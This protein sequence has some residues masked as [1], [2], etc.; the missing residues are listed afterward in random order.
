MYRLYIGAHF[1]IIPALAGSTVQVRLA[2]V[3][4]G[5]HPRACGEHCG[6]LMATAL[7]KGSSPRLRGAPDA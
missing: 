4:D 2:V 6:Q 1:G 7:G 5:D 3:L